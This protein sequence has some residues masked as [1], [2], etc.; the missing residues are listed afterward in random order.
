[1]GIPRFNR[2]PNPVV[3]LNIELKKIK[4]KKNKF[5]KRKKRG[6]FEFIS[7]WNKIKIICGVL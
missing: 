7:T 3:H 5:K 2:R 6:K 4:N 1:L